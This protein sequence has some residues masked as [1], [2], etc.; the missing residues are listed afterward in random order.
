MPESTR[1]EAFDAIVALPI[2][3]NNLIRTEN[4]RA[5]IFWAQGIASPPA[6]PRQTRVQQMAKNLLATWVGA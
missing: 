6:R 3:P 1:R 2:Q 4:A 5:T